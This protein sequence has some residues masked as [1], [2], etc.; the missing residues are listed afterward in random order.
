M[1]RRTRAAPVAGS[2]LRDSVP[3]VMKTGA[4][5]AVLAVSGC[6]ADSAAATIT[7]EDFRRA[8]AD[9]DSSA[10]CWMLSPHTREEVAGGTR[11]EDQVTSLKIP[12][13]GAAVRTE[14][15]GRNALVEFPDDTVFLTVSGSGWRVTGAGCRAQGDAPYECEVGGQ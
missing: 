10:E 6:A 12:S 8:A 15:Y 4:L 1:K 14:R 5:L 9:G 11:C 3:K 2:R 7:A 13:E